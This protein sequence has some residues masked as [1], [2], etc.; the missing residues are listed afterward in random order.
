M[1]EKC[2]KLLKK[3]EEG[4]RAEERRGAGGYGGLVKLVGPTAVPGHTPYQPPHLVVDTVLHSFNFQKLK[5]GN[6]PIK[7]NK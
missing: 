2:C 7:K 3:K 1:N 6:C 5:G 4:G